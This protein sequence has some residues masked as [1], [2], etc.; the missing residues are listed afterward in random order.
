MS[1]D[2][3]TSEVKALLQQCKVLVKR[4][5]SCSETPW[6]SVQEAKSS[7]PSRELA[8]E[9]VAAY[10]RTFESTYR[11]LHIPSF[12]QEYERYWNDPETANSNYVVILMLVM[13]IGVCF[14]Q[15]PE[16]E[17]HLRT[18]AR[19]WTHT[20][21]SW[22][23]PLDKGQLTLGY[24]QAQ[25]LLVLSRQINS[26]SADL[27]WITAGTLLRTAILMGL[28]REPSLFPKLSVLQAEMRRR[29][30][31]TILELCV[32]TSLDT[33]LTPMISMDEFDTEPPSNID[34]NE[35]DETTLHPPQSKDES[36]L[37]QTSAQIILRRSLLLRFEVVR[38]INDSQRE[39]SY[40][41]VLALSTKLTDI[42]RE[43]IS[44]AQLHSSRH[45]GSFLT[46]FRRNFIEFILHRFQIALHC[47][48]AMKAR[49]DPRFYYSRKVCLEIG[50]AIGSPEHDNDFYRLMILGGIPYRE[51]TAH[52][53]RTVCLELVVQIEEDQAN[54]VPLQAAKTRRDPIHE[55]VKRMFEL[56]KKR[57]ENAETNVKPFVFFSMVLAQV[58]AMEKGITL[59]PAILD[60]ATK[61]T[62]TCI[63][64]LNARIAKLPSMGNI[65]QQAMDTVLDGTDSFEN[66]GLDSFQAGDLDDLTRSWLFPGLDDFSFP[67]LLQT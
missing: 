46:T 14:Y 2:T 13:A 22:L 4:I 21:N 25:C 23:A 65:P 18:F 39:P 67:S 48:F 43:T 29:L 8:D 58:D 5:K 32:S 42:W 54:L 7:F 41:E 37:T 34:D 30:W 40:D 27:M 20:A 45:Q 1:R 28:H 66:L 55:T 16:D 35:M 15:G 33:G 17:H 31:S 49:K 38:L 3:A 56:S 26:I 52:I 11:I 10:F 57:I 61:S 44:W 64:L 36:I 9:L 59:E 6:S 53:I 50:L 63:E 47:P 24:L 60:A 51:I 62:K 19:R 12:Q